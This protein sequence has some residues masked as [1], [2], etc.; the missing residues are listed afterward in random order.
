MRGIGQTMILSRKQMRRGARLSAL[1]AVAG[2]SVTFFSTTTAETVDALGR[3]EFRYLFTA[4]A[5]AGLDLWIGAGRY[6]ILVRKIKPGTSPLLCFR[7]NL[8]NLFMGAVTPSQSGGGP[9]QLFILF[10]GGV[11]FSAAVSVCV[12]TFLCTL[13]FFLTAASLSIAFVHDQFSGEA[14]RLFVRY[15]FVVFVTLF[16][17]VL[18][19]LWKTDLFAGLLARLARHLA[20]T[21]TRIGE[22]L[23]RLL[24]RTVAETD[25]YRASCAVFLKEEPRLVMASFALT[26]LMYLNKFTLAYFVLRGLGVEVDYLSMIAVQTLLLFILY[27]A[28]SPGGSGIAELSTAAL[29]ATLMPAYL[30]PLFTLLSRAFHLYFPAALGAFVMLA[31]VNRTPGSDRPGKLEPIPS[32]EI[33][34]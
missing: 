8:A 9:A 16:A 25:R 22:R 19:A 17:V 12:V 7:A 26:V 1:L 20:W 18:F 5:L 24:V 11:P 33:P 14:V 34:V 15:A 4:A 29:M 30:L 27:F 32:V 31:E 13:V 6:H 28:P 10:R 2:L 3:L 21:G 23:S